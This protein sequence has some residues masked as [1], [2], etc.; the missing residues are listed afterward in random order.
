MSKPTNPRLPFDDPAAVDSRLSDAVDRDAAVDPQR[1]VVLEA[2][3]GTGKTRVLVNRYTNL[4]LA[5]VDPKNILAITFT[6]KAAAEM[7]ERILRNLERTADQGGIDQVRWADLR[8]R[9]GDVA[10][11]TVDAFCLSLLREFPLEADLDPGFGMADETEATRLVDEA[12][13]RAMRVCRGVAR[14]DTSVALVL[15]SLGERLLRRGLAALLDRRL[16][17]GAALARAVRRL[18]DGLSAA[19]AAGQL[20]AS[21]RATFDGGGGIGAFVR[22]GP[23]HPRFRVLATDLARLIGKPPGEAEAFRFVRAL[24][25]GIGHHFFTRANTPRKRL[26]YPKEQFASERARK[27][28]QA[29]VESLAPRLADDVKRFRRD[30]NGVLTRGVWRCFGV[31]AAEYRRTLEHHAVVDFPEALARALD[32]VSEM[33]EF[34]RSRFVLESRYHHLLIDEFQDTSDAQWRL[35]WQ[36]VQSWREGIG[37]AE[38]MPLEPTIFVVGDRKQSIYGFRDADVGVLRR[39]AARIAELRGSREPVKRAIRRSFRAVPELLAFTNALCDEMEK[40]NDRPD[41]F[42]YEEADRF[43]IDE[44][45]PRASE[46]ALGVVATSDL[47]ASARAV[48]AEVAR[49]LATGVVRDRLTGI[50]RTA[51]PADMAILFRSR[52]GH[53]HFEAALEEEAVPSY[54]YKGLG[55]F[56][57]EEVKDI[58]AALAFLADSASDLRAAAFLR[59][60]FI[61]LSD[62]GLSVLA[63][64]LARSLAGPVEGDAHLEPDDTAVM[65]IVRLHVP[66]WLALADRVPPAELLDRVIS[67]SAYEFELAGPRALQARENLKKVRALVRRI[68]NRGYLTLARASEHL[69]RLSAGDESNAAI[70]AA[71]AVSLMTVHAAKGLEFP[72]VFL[73]NLGKGAG[74]GRDPI[75]LAG[76]T[77]DE[78]PVVAVGDFKSE[79]DDDALARDREETKRLLYVAVTRARDRLYLGSVLGRD[80][81]FLAGR[82]G[83]GEALPPGLRQAIAS[84]TS[85]SGEIQWRTADGTAHRLRVCPVPEGLGQR[86]PRPQAA[87]PSPTDFGVLRSP[88]GLE[89]ADVTAAIRIAPSRPAG[90]SLGL[91]GGA[92]ARLVG[93]LVHRLLGRL[94]LGPEP[95]ERLRSTAEGL[96]RRDERLAAAD[97]A[98]VLDTAVE[99]YQ[100]VAGRPELVRLFATADRFHEVPIALLENGR[101]LR[102]AVDALVGGRDGS[103]TV[104]EFKT[105]GSLPEHQ[106]QLDIYVGAVRALF[107]GVVKITGLLV[108]P[109]PEARFLF[110]S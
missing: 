40:A 6:R 101:I 30:L 3:A 1:N 18:P 16:A 37:T 41:A 85:A 55:F 99:R 64:H 27:Q 48:A 13:D 2:S 11:G 75:R 25:D 106:A 74:G 36:L 82:G 52:E 103:V 49:L 108:Y 56:D 104:V 72:V 105:G 67:D 65:T 46:P 35:V 69:G 107:P 19:T 47:R 20:L 62:R 29:L 38:G 80:G 88:A 44:D 110:T 94:G 96:L 81:A 77:P 91:R 24:V 60:R 39:A 92:D 22:T 109:D 51:K 54:V 98:A 50:A 9:L 34:T 58:V 57:T 28:H 102:G 89:R 43:P 42:T 31:A 73:V 78:T 70:D 68:Q 10:I 71:D 33:E 26:A 90:P 45:A 12:L 83:L 76:V 66:R 21:L 8:N 7:R 86:A 84:A 23:L 59:S 93:T 61:R 63:P 17:A 14:E 53:Q 97:L 32:L 100:A 87:G 15:A 95:A 4:I 79:A 5:G